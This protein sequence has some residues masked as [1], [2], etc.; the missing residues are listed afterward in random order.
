MGITNEP[1]SY[2]IKMVEGTVCLQFRWALSI[3]YAGAYYQKEEQEFE[4]RVTTTDGNGGNVPWDPLDANDFF[5]GGTTFFGR[6]RT[7]EIEQKALFG[8]ATYDFAER[9]QVK[10]G[11]RWFDVDLT[12]IQ[13]NLHNFGGGANTPAGEIIGE[14]V[15]GN[16]VGRIKGSERQRQSD[17]GPV[18][19]G[20]QKT[21]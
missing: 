15:N 5:A 9:W 6:F 16:K 19:P 11:L 7:D 20:D 13:G 10:G 8:E 12:S 2:N 21:S 17:G 4:V 14:T 3:L 1:Q 18:L